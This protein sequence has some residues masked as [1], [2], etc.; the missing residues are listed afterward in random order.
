MKNLWYISYGIFG[1]KYN[2]SEDIVNNQTPSMCFWSSKMY[3]FL[4]DDTTA[5]LETNQ[6]TA[7]LPVIFG[8]F[9]CT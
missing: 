8:V 6:A 2:F 7:F 1:G 4:F 5:Q 3:S 9:T